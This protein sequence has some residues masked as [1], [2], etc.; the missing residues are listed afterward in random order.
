MIGLSNRRP[1]S[2]EDILIAITSV[3]RAES[4]S[5]VNFCHRLTTFGFSVSITHAHSSSGNNSGRNSDCK[6]LQCFVRNS[7]TP[8]LL[9]SN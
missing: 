4:L 5:V 7:S 9:R 1:S 6:L 8:H 2:S 3:I